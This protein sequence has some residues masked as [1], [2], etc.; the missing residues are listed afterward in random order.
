MRRKAPMPRGGA[1][2]GDIKKDLTQEQLAGIGAATTSFNDLEF[3]LDILVAVSISVPSQL[4]MDVVKRLRGL[5][6]KIDIAKLA[7][8]H[9]EN[10]VT[11]VNAPKAYHFSAISKSS[12]GAFT[13]Q[14]KYRDLIVHSRVYDWANKIGEK[15][16]LKAQHDQI[17]LS[18]EAL[19]WVYKMNVHLTSELNL[20][21]NYVSYVTQHLVYDGSP[22][23]NRLLLVPEALTI[24]SK[25]RLHQ[26]ERASLGPAP[27]FPDEYPT[28]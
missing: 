26:K 19:N 9:W 22:F 11:F 21:R 10:M 16:G 3:E 18:E 4:L 13:E 28:G 6:D 27:K 20:I 7:I 5:E 2:H 8:D 15:I 25:T 14:K 23:P 24:L 12:L 17:L 1:R